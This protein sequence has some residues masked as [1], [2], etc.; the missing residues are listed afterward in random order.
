MRG[1]ERSDYRRGWLPR[2]W[3]YVLNRAAAPLVPFALARR[4]ALP[5]GD[6]AYAIWSRPREA[7]LQNYGRVLR[8]PVDDPLVE[9]AARSCF[10]HFAMYIAEMLH[11]QGW[12]TRTVL[13]R[14]EIEGAEHFERAE[15][16]G[17]G[18]IFVSAHMGSAEV[19]AAV[20]VLRGYDITAVTETLRPQFVMDWAIACRA[21]MGIRLL[22]VERAGISLLRAL[23]REEMVAFV[24]DAGVERGGGVPAS[25]LGSETVFPEGPARL[26]RLSGAPIVF[27]VAP[28]LP[29]GRFRAH[30]EPPLLSERSLPPEEDAGCLTQRLA[31]AF[32]RYVRRYP[33]QWYAFREMWPVLQQQD[34]GAQRSEDQWSE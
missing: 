14:L 22:P 33:G 19:A 25:F 16:L 20:A 7:A 2:P 6:L 29:G 11:V 23:R 21:A 28:R 8:R 18:I 32:E 34:V 9:R 27:A 26:A 1:A 30:I 3:G 5:W 10:R 13:E 31:S 17:K 15:A 4:I 24:I 12:D